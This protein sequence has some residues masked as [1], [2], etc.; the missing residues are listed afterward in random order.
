GGGR[1]GGVGAGPSVDGPPGARGGERLL[2]GGRSARA[3][4]AR[5]APDVV[6]VRGGGDDGAP[7]DAALPAEVHAVRD[8]VVRGGHDAVVRAAGDPDPRH[9][10]GRRVALGAPCVASGA[11][12]ARGFP[13]QGVRA[14]SARPYVMLYISPRSRPKLVEW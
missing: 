8:G 1:A 4:V 14:V 12:R 13:A 5:C 6:H 9:A 10:D 3:P 2:R 11:A 7:L